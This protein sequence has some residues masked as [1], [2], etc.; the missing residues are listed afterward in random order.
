MPTLREVRRLRVFGNRALRR[1][2]GPKSDKVTRKWA[3]QH[4][5]ELNDLYSSPIIVLVIKSKGM[6]WA[7]M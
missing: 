1:T 2:F 4:N 5:E 3:K 7:G 6:C